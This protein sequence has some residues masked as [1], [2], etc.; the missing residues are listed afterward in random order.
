MFTSIAKAQKSCKQL[1]FCFEQKQSTNLAPTLQ[2]VKLQDLPMIIASWHANGSLTCAFGQNNDFTRFA[3]AW[4][5][6]QNPPVACFYDNK[7]NPG[8]SFGR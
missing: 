8:L 2:K 1:P 4:H 5:R 6:C 7:I 3:D